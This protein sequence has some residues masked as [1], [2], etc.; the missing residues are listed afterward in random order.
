MG[1]FLRSLFAAAPERRSVGFEDS[2]VSALLG[3]GAAAKSGVFVTPEQA[4]KCTTALAATRALAQGIAQPAFGL[5]RPWAADKRGWEPA[6]D[7]PLWRI[8]TAQP[9]DWQTSYEFRETMMIHA[10]LTGNGV[11]FI[12]RVG[13]K[14]RELIPILPGHCSIEQRP[15]YDLVYRLTL[16][17]GTMLTLPRS[18]V[19]H[20]RGMSW[21]TYEGMDALR[22][23][24][25]AVGLALVTEETHARLHSNGA[26]PGGILTTEPNADLSEPQ[27]AQIKAAWQEAQGG[28]HNAMKT[29]ILTGGLKWTQLSMTGVDAQHLETRRFQIEE[30]CRGLG[31]FPVIVGHSDKT[32][33]FA[34]VEAFLQAHVTLSLTPWAERV[35]QVWWRDLLTDKEKSEGYAF[36][37]DLRS[38]ERGDT[39]ARTEYYASGIQQGW[40]LRNEARIA[41]GYNPLPGLDE[42][43]AP[44]NMGNGSAPATPPAATTGP[45][46]TKAGRVLS[47][48][49][50]AR[51]VGARDNLN[52]VLAQVQTEDQT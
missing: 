46:A 27:V 51:L 10:I 24:R 52:T 48:S 30:I 40:L 49:N 31:V 32:A 23:A 38:L 11:A 29:A 1:G 20:L 39:K 42:P 19:L 17:D 8:V 35:E 3:G 12:N 36:D 2:F 16:A 13:G 34:S 37:I 47:A 33:T 21:N 41:E 26:R 18:S 4:L 22:L 44:L 6:H 14:V 25:E 28:V 7:H 43:L 5:Y 50:E 45:K 9:N 15:N